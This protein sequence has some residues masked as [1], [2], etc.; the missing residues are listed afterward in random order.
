MASRVPIIDLQHMRKTYSNVHIIIQI[1]LYVE[2]CMNVVHVY[3]G[4]QVA[5]VVGRAECDVAITY[6]TIPRVMR[7]ELSSLAPTFRSLWRGTS[8]SHHT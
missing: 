4:C 3:R 2:H 7:N 8:V 1:I 5:M 6:P